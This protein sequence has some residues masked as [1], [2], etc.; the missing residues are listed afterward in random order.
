MNIAVKMFYRFS[1]LSLSICFGACAELTPTTIEINATPTQIV[2]NEPSL[3]IVSTYTMPASE[4]KLSYKFAFTPNHRLWTRGSSDS[5]SNQ[6][7]F[8]DDLGKSWT[9]VDLP[10][11]GIAPHSVLFIDQKNGWAMDTFDV[12]KTRDGGMTWNEVPLPSNHKMAELNAIEFRDINRGFIAGSTSYISDRGKSTVSYGIEI[13]CTKDAGKSWTICYQN[14]ENNR[15]WQI[16]SLGNSTVFLVD[17]KVLL[18][19]N[20]DGITWERKQLD[21]PAMDIEPDSNGVLWTVGEDGFI[22]SS[23]DFGDTWQAVLLSLPRDPEFS[24]NSVS[25]DKTGFGAAVG[26]TGVVAITSNNGL[27]WSLQ[28][29]LKL[30]NDLW[31]VRV[32]NPY[33]VVSDESHLYTL[34]LN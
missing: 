3:T 13:L 14:K 22:R 16:F 25:I 17:Q 34:R 30:K 32:Q 33:V 24:W 4:G 28:P 7:M 9:F 19:T 5:K 23:R 12:L 27:S 31:T 21:F 15:I 1:I 8:S 29:Q 18:I 20:D 2:G 6:M 10:S 26:D 11:R